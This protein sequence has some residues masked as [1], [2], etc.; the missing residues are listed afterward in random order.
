V[1]V[2][3]SQLGG[4]LDEDQALGGRDQRQQR[5]QQRGLART[6]AA[7]DE[8]GQATP[9]DLAEHPGALL[10]DRAGGDQLVEGQGALLGNPQREQRARSGQRREH[11]MEAGAVAQPDVDVRGGVVEATPAGGGQTLGEAAYRLL[12]GE[13]DLGPLEACATV[14]VDLVGTVDEH[15]GHAGQPQERLEGPRTDHVAS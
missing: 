11:G 1:R 14:D 6:G 13:A 9:D 2:V 3:G 4:V 8:E 7:A 10:A 5:P 12:V 15:V